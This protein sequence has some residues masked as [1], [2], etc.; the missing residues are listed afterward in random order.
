MRKTLHNANSS[1]VIWN[2]YGTG[3]SK[4][5]LKYFDPAR[6]VKI[7]CD[8]SSSGL[9]AVLQQ[10]VQPVAYSSRSLNNA[11]IRCVQIE[12]TIVSIVHACVKF[13][14]NIFATHVSLQWTQ[15]SR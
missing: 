4:K 15:A 8:P 2:V 13:H 5:L 10:D 14:N 11:E 3:D 9:G 6:P 7:F 12:G 1:N